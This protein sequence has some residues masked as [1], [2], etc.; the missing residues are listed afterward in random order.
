MLFCPFCR[1][2]FEGHAECPEHE[3]TLVEIDRL[4]RGGAR[5]S[6]RVTFF[7]DPRLGRGTVLL[8]AALV[9][10]GFFMPFAGARGI[11]GSALEV[12]IDGAGNLWFTPGAAVAILCILWRRRSRQSMRAARVAVIGLAAGGA[13]PLIYTTRRIGLVAQSASA[14][15]A[16][17]AGLWVMLV[18]LLVVALGSRRLGSPR[19]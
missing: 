13:L 9:L 6:D 16:W 14:Q 3:L 17:H 19:G 5:N 2:A 12:A 8:G 1:E 15:V 7:V 11:V 4:P 18:G 10:C